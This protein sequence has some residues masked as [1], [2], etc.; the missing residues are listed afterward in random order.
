MCWLTP[1]S[2]RLHVKNSFYVKYCKKIQ[3]FHYQY[4]SCC[5]QDAHSVFSAIPLALYLILNTC[6][7]VFRLL[8]L[9]RREHWYQIGTW[10]CQEKYGFNSTLTLLSKSGKFVLQLAETQ[11]PKLK[12]LNSTQAHIT[13]Y[14]DSIIPGVHP[15]YI[16]LNLIITSTGELN[17]IQPQYSFHEQG[18]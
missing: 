5:Q 3:R 15:V 14:N 10:Y 8:N 16:T 13:V 6:S 1:E 17:R 9:G 4:Y 11:N 7:E 18:N 2:D 12:L